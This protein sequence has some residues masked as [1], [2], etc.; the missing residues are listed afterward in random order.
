[1]ALFLLTIIACVTVTYRTPVNSQKAEV[2]M[3]TAATTCADRWKKAQLSHFPVD[4][5]LSGTLLLPTADQRKVTA[6]RLPLLRNY[7]AWWK[8]SLWGTS[9]WPTCWCS[10]PPLTLFSP[11]PRSDVRSRQ[12]ILGLDLSHRCVG[13]GGFCLSFLQIHEAPQHR[14]DLR[15]DFRMPWRGHAITYDQCH[16]K[17]TFKMPHTDALSLFFT[18]H[19]CFQSLSRR[20]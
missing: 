19:P 14:Q 1:M 3:M 2:Q 4:E 8:I 7:F 6:K 17:V 5:S 12:D 10:S 16:F 11:K 13:R 20:Y 9:N 18:Y 15:T